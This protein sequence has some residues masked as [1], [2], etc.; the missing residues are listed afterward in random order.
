MFTH[1]H[2][3]TNKV[4]ALNLKNSWVTPVVVLRFQLRNLTPAETE[5]VSCY[6]L[7]SLPLESNP[8]CIFI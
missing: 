3:Q 1:E 4:K 7:E 5:T 8:T 2:L 6:E